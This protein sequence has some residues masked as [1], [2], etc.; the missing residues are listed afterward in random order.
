MEQELEILSRRKWRK[1]NLTDL[2]LYQ[3][4]R[5][6]GVGVV[7][8]GAGGGADVGCDEGGDD[9]AGAGRGGV[10]SE[11]GDGSGGGDEK[12]DGGR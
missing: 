12:S 5:D 7:G 9:A 6:G 4:G 2:S 1:L 10:G 11:G 3:R 8:V